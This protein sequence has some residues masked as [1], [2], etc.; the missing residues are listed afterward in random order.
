MSAPR[1]FALAVCLAATA[2]AS[3]QTAPLTLGQAIAEALRNSPELA[4]PADAVSAADVSRRQAA[5]PFGVHVMPMLSGF[6]T[7]G[8]YGGQVAGVTVGSRLQTGADVSI[9]ASSNTF[10]SGGAAYR[11]RG[12]SVGV[13]QPITSLFSHAA[14]APLEE[15]RSGVD[16]AARRLADAR[17]QLIVDVAAAYYGVLQAEELSA[18]AV[19]ARDRATD[20]VAAADAR[21]RAGLD[22]QL[23]VMRAQLLA[24]QAET[25]VA[26]RTDAVAEA[27]ERLNLIL[28]RPIDGDVSLTGA[29]ETF[30]PDAPPDA[31]RAIAEALAARADVRDA[32]ARVRDA[33]RA[34]EIARWNVLPPVTV[35]VEYAQHG[36]GSPLQPLYQPYNGWHVSLTSSY[37]IDRGG[38]A[39]SVERSELAIRAAERQVQD[40]EQRVAAEVRQALRAVA[41][42]DA[43][44]PQQRQARDLAARQLELA[45]LRYE[46]GLADNLTVVDAENALAQAET[47]CITG[48]IAQR[49]A[50]LRLAR[51]IG[52]LTE[53]A[54]T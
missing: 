6:S 54:R 9:T 10:A 25:A 38:A 49:L 47:A 7:S 3:A 20:L 44:V 14:A 11:D 12:I 48:V 31:E 35:N 37:A 16:S 1:L 4:A 28:G 42:A 51:A 36:F 22:T 5:A 45:R 41:R 19:R 32:T 2:R 13:S 46:R 50:R 17:Q 23:D 30:V 33:R 26:D 52:T 21:A 29:P 15:A 39:A 27:H 18:A 34:L 40:A 8:G 43:S 24:S 53:E